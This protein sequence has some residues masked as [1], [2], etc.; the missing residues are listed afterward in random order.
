MALNEAVVNRINQHA[1]RTFDKNIEDNYLGKTTYLLPIDYIEAQK[2]LC[3]Y[4]VDWKSMDNNQQ[5]N[6]DI[7]SNTIEIDDLFFDLME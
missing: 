6:N 5:N 4:L 7:Y 2:S 3:F 1:N